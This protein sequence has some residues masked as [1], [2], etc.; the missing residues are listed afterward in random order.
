MRVSPFVICALGLTAPHLVLAQAPAAPAPSAMPALP[1]REVTVFKDGYAF[2]LQEGGLPVNAAGEVVLDNLPMPV[3]GT[4]WPYQVGGKLRGVVASRQPVTRQQPALSIYDL[5]QAN[6]GADV[7]IIE[8][9]GR[10]LPERRFDAKILDLPRPAA[11]EPLPNET[12]AERNQRLQ[13]SQVILLQTKD[14]VLARTPDS[15]S[16]IIFKNPPRQT[17]SSPEFR[18]LLRLQLGGTPRKTGDIA[19]VGMVYLQK[20]LRWI[21]SYR[22]SLDAGGRA[23]VKMQATLVNEMVDLDNTTVNLVIG[24]PSFAF[25]DTL[26]PL[27]LQNTLA[28]LSPLFDTNSRSANA[29][30]NAIQSQVASSSYGRINEGEGAAS[31]VPGDVAGGSNEDFFVFSAP[32]LSLKKGER[33]EFPLAQYNLKYQDIYTQEA[34][35]T[36]PSE[37]YRELSYEQQISVHKSLLAPS[38]MHKIRLLNT[39]TQPLT[40][41]PTLIESD[42]R[43]LAQTLMTYTATGGRSDLDLA[44]AVDVTFKRRETEG[45]RTLN[46]LKWHNEDYSRVDVGG[47]LVVTSY[48][49]TPI[50]VE[51]TQQFIGT[52]DKAEMG[53][54]I[55]KLGLGDDSAS[56]AGE[57][58]PAWWNYNSGDWRSLN[59]LSSVHWSVTVPAKG[60]VELPYAYHYF[61]R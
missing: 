24:V 35:A 58:L 44:P 18:N 16:Q 50:T 52:V 33:M 31:N 13:P 3:V 59:G 1:V 39:G 54:A 40:T 30:S 29:L 28:R 60:S 51:L 61:W 41:A 5:L 57:N 25:K 34:P 55:R 6:I 45:K 23:A 19:Q 48:H 8:A 46:A 22:L 15:I 7:T 2:V 10:D 49:N 37:M 9:P 20:G 17:T 11:T 14:G 53:G 36:P 38:V 26:D 27:A 21:P 42:G 43:L 32:H 12:D 47:R 4:F 56:S